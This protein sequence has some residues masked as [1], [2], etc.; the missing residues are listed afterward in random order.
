LDRSITPAGGWVLDRDYVVRAIIAPTTVEL[1]LDGQRLVQAASTST[2][3]LNLDSVR[4]G[5]VYES[6]TGTPNFMVRQLAL[7][8]SS[9]SGRQATATLPSLTAVPPEVYLFEPHVPVALPWRQPASETLTVETTFRFIRR[10]ALETLKPMVDAYGQSR[11]AQWAGK[12]TSDTQLHASA[13]DEAARHQAWGLPASHDEY[14]GHG[15]FRETATGFYRVVRR[16]EHWWLITPSG[17]PTFYLGLDTAPGTWSPTRV[18]GRSTLFAWLPPSTGEYAAAWSGDV[19]SFVTANLIRKHGASWS[20]LS[21]DNLVSRMK[22]W[23]FTGVGKGADDLG[24]AVPRVT[25]LKRDGV[26]VLAGGHPDI[27]DSSVRAKFEQ[28]LQASILGIERPDL[29][30]GW[31]LGGGTSEIIRKA[32]VSS[33]L[34]MYPSVAAKLALVDHAVDV[35][36]TGDLERMATAW[37]VVASPPLSRQSFYS[38]LNAQPP[39]EDL[40]ALRRYFA[41]RYYAFIRETVKRLDPYPHLFLGFWFIPGQWENEEDWRIMARHVDV[42]GFDRYALAYD[43]A[44]VQRLLGETD[45]PALIGEFSFPAHYSAARGV[46]SSTLSAMDE[47]HAGTL[48]E[49]WTRTAA[50][51]PYVIGQMWFQYRDLPITGRGNTASTALVLGNSQPY[52]LVDVTDRPKWPL[53]TAVRQANLA[54]VEQRLVAWNF[55]YQGEDAVRSGAVIA[56]VHSGYTS[57]GYADFINNSGD[58]VEWTVSVAASGVHRLVFRYANGGT[59]SRPLELRV[60]N[61]LVGDLPFAPTGGWTDWSTQAQV[62]TL[63]AGTHKVRLTAKGASGGNIDYLQVV[64]TGTR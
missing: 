27:F 17:N 45:K 54:A 7:R 30:V 44:L 64:D 38:A 39:A 2:P 28:T 55:F 18:T 58:S 50:K 32:E 49:Q 60:D 22:Y 9:S 46:G 4:A 3:S 61:V 42:I 11:H 13:T 1:W 47:A 29:L 33:I 16:F 57:T 36:Y 25:V 40:E 23:G 12:V 19:F 20:T 34:A 37:K 59:A 48:Y 35:L 8:V 14:G 24:R 31:S 5:D 56:S 26:P 53:V 21:R 52:G 62:L 51:D 63:G 15:G 6:N 10:P 41:D 43:D